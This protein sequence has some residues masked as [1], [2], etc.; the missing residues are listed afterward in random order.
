MPHIRPATSAD[1]PFIHSLAPRLA[2]VADLPWRSADE[3]MRFQRSFMHETLEAPKPGAVTLVA[4][5]EAGTKLGFVHAEP[6]LDIFTDNLAA[7]IPLL[8]VAEAAE[9]HGAAK[10]LMAAVEDWARRQ[11]YASLS[12]DVFASNSRGRAFYERQGY[13]EETLRL[14]KD[15]R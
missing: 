1:L 4:E 9:G 8:A 13:G 11:G 2:G 7:Y 12:L 3:V 14:V 5:D 6:M 10:V 15:I